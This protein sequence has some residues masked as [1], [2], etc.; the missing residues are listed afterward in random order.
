MRNKVREG[1]SP[2]AL[3]SHAVCKAGGCRRSTGSG[4]SVERGKRV[5]GS[6]SGGFVAFPTAHR[7]PSCP[8]W[9][10]PRQAEPLQPGV[11]QR[12]WRWG[13]GG[14]RARAARPSLPSA[15]AL[16]AP[17]TVSLGPAA[18]PINFYR[19]RK[20]TSG[21]LWQTGFYS[22]CTRGRAWLSLNF[23][24]MS[25]SSWMERKTLVIG[26]PGCWKLSQLL[27]LQSHHQP[28]VFLENKHKLQPVQEPRS[29]LQPPAQLQELNFDAL[30]LEQRQGLDQKHHFPGQD[31]SP[32]GEQTRLVLPWASGR[33][34]QGP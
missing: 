31:Q 28:Y 34:T 8:P 33:P 13:A 21:S 32:F 26:Y 22:S 29:H 20:M 10:T 9:P 2:A 3:G 4:S 7:S 25:L 30:S 24:Q 5:S 19:K 23:S 6:S 15:G 14:G 27:L 17:Q 1:V 18:F 16:S 11:G 12:L